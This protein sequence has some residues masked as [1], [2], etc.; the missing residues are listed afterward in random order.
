MK[1]VGSKA[2]EIIAARDEGSFKDSADFCLRVRGQQIN[3]RVLE[4]LLMCGAF[5]SLERNRA[6]LWAA[7]DDVM[8]WAAQRAEE[9]TSPQIGL[10]AASG[11][12]DAPPP[13]L[14]DAVTWRPEDELAREREAIGLFITGH[15]LDR[16]E[17]DLKKFTNCSTGTLRTKGA[18]L[19]VV[20]DRPGRDARPRVRLGG[21]IHTIKLRNSKKRGERYAQFRLEDKE[22]VVDVVMWPDTYR[23]FE[24]LLQGGAP[25]VVAGALEISTERCQVIADELVPLATARAEA[26]RQAHVRVPPAAGR[27]VLEQLKTILAAHPGP[28][29]TFLHLVRPDDTIAVLALP[30]DIRVAASD[31]IVNAVETV[32]GAGVISFR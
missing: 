18:D 27:D 12:V 3:R 17:Q 31:E 7:I 20:S 32:L 22:G 2:I 13:P 15:P 4:C 19:P 23:K 21:V 25:V 28:C 1:G 9:K 14:P 26:I 8:R 30:R 24:T 29:D 10:F 16:Y 5:D 6:R 11:V